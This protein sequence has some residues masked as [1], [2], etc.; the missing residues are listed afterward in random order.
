MP[1]VV[2]KANAFD[3]V[4]VCA[5]CGGKAAPDL[6]DFQRMGQPGAVVIPFIVYKYLR[7]VLQPAKSSSMQ[8][9]VT[10][11]LV[12]STVQVFLFGVAAALRFS[13]LDCV[14]RKAAGFFRFTLLARDDHR[15]L[16]LNRDIAQ[17]AEV[18]NGD[19]VNSVSQHEISPR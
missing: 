12:N 1:K 6:G 18:A 5:E 14:R 16:L 19:A 2:R 17:A 7:L 11:T 4:R 13:A 9:P 8:N 3:K 15:R 10:V